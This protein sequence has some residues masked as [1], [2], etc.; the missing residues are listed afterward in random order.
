MNEYMQIA[1]RAALQAGAEI[2]KV[3]E[4][5]DFNVESKADDSPLT[6][7][8]QRA[9]SLIEEALEHTGL[10]MLSEEG[11]EIPSGQR[12]YWDLYWLIAPWTVPRSL[13]NATASLP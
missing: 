12:S 5:D 10:P 13:S 9:H 7:A 3:Y 1:Y 11:A 8:D 4:S 2:L 6:L